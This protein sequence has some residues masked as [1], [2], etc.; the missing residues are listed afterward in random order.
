VDT[1]SGRPHPGALTENALRDDI[2]WDNRGGYTAVPGPGEDL[3]IEHTDDDGN[4]VR[5]VVED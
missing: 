2:G 3:V 4:V 5:I 1:D